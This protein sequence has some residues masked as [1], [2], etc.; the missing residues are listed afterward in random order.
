MT[1]ALI[2]GTISSL[3]F[4]L[5]FVLNRSMGLSGGHWIW[6]A[7]L[8]YVFMFLVLA[9]LMVP[10]R[11]FPPL[12]REIRS[13]PRPWLLWSFVGFGVF[14]SF[15]C[16][17]SL[18][19]PSWMVASSWQ[20]TIVAGVLLTPLFGA[21]L[22]KRQLVFSLVILVGVVLVQSTSFTSWEGGASLW[23]LLFIVVAAVAYPLGNRKMMMAM[24]TPIGTLERVFGMT[25]CSMPLWI[26]LMVGA[27]SVGILP[28]GSQVFQT[29]LVAVF[30]GVVATLLFF[31]ATDLVKDNPR[32]LA[33]VESLQA[34]EVVFALVL[35]VL[36]LHEDFPS[37]IALLGLLVIGVGMA[38]N[39]KVT[40]A[41]AA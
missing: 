33:L 21:K 23:G 6:T 1:K 24:K 4:A 41:R 17:S 25:L 29:F 20:T 12:W 32:H 18:F 39:Y 16:L 19:S 15:V 22:P 11:R 38:L 26:V 13:N 35:G 36:F 9:A 3:F 27:A 10:K 2:Y 37:P 14:Y 7:S 8:R 30:S 5:T 34:G 28:T 31:R 40:A